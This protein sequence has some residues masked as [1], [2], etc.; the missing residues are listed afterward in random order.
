MNK[1]SAALESLPRDTSN[2][3]NRCTTFSGQTIY[4]HRSYVHEGISS[5]VSVPTCLTP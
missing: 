5:A 4:T 3:N 1:T 2:N